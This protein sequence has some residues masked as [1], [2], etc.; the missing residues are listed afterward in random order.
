M[1]IG[2]RIHRL[3]RNLLSWFITIVVAFV[4]VFVT[5]AFAFEFVRI[6]GNSM[7]DTLQS[8]ELLL[9]TKLDYGT[10]WLTTPWQSLYEQE[11]ARR[12]NV[13]FG[14][15][16]RG[17]IVIVRYP[18]SGTND[19]VKRIVGLPG[20]VIALHDGF[21]YVNGERLDESYINDAY[22]AMDAEWLNEL[23]SLGLQDSMSDDVANMCEVRIP[24]S[25]DA[26]TFGLVGS[27]LES[28]SIYVNGD[29]Y[30]WWDFGS[31]MHD[32]D[33]NE[34]RVTSYGV[35]LNN[36]EVDIYDA[37]QSE[38]LCKQVFY[39]DEDLYFV[40]GDHRNDSADSR[41]VGPVGR[42]YIVGHAQQVVFP[43]S[44]WKGL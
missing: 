31:S 19:F 26:I 25:G 4:V 24:R 15:I 7:L 40:M 32:A 43:F 13:G 42:S 34:L 11:S 41:V 12:L 33:G 30:P 37:Q 2:M 38:Q 5:K 16:A 6:D 18:G 39:L 44:E 28:I 14:D 9:V 23:R 17:D 1:V 3:L 35:F 21:V 10:I 20:D 36:N 22:R 27:S 8:G 29:L